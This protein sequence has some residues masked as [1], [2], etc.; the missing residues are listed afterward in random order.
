MLSQNLR[1]VCPVCIHHTFMAS[2]CDQQ[3]KAGEARN[4]LSAA[5]HCGGMQNNKKT[6]LETAEEMYAIWVV[7]TLL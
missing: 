2:N 1:S 3:D 7:H 5:E 4:L 6:L